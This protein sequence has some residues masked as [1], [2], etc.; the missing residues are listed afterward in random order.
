MTTEITQLPACNDLEAFLLLHRRM[1][2]ASFDQ[3]DWLDCL[4]GTAIR[5]EEEAT[6]PVA[7]EGQVV[8]KVQNLP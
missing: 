8:R 4:V 3:M 2:R 5:G 7:Q 6:L 1:N